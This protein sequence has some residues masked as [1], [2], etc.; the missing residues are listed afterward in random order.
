MELSE[1]PELIKGFLL[2]PTETFRK[3]R[4]TETGEAFKYLAI[5]AAIFSVLKGVTTIAQTNRLMESVAV[6]PKEVV[7]IAAI[8]LNFVAAIAGTIIGGV[9]LHIFVYIV[10]GREGIEQTIKAEIYAQ[11]PN[12]L[13]GW[14][15]FIGA[16]TGIWSAVLEV[17]GIRELQKLSTGRAILA[18]LL[19]VTIAILL[20][21]LVSMSI[22]QMAHQ[23]TRI[24]GI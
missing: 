8:P 16:I 7:G 2:S 20:A 19:P 1:I 11:T 3:V 9:I 24:A 6:I 10:G 22:S 13:L 12:L 4:K 14:I 5:L 21:F 15:P 23:M 17:I 18:V